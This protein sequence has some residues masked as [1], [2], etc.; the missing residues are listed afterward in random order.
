MVIK[1][2]NEDILLLVIPTTTYS[3]KV[4]VMVGS[5]IIDWAMG[6]ITK[7]ELVKA[8]M[9][10][11]QVHF[12]AVMYG[13]L[14]MPHTSSH[15]TREE[16]EVIHSSP[17]VDTVEVKEFCLNNVCSP[18]CT[19]QRVTIPPFGMVSIQGNTSVRG[20]CMQVHILAEPKP[21]PQLPTLVVPTATYGELHPGSSQVPI[22]L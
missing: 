18:V 4:P 22:C 21:D 14:Q 10:W 6:V 20:H 13:S 9:T 7:V 19:T 17:G 1:N 8:T 15:G 12:R 3:E 16:K 11:Q 5:K 2:Y